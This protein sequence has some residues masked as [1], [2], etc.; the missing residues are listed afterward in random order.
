MAIPL[1]VES[2]PPGL[3]GINLKQSFEPFGMWCGRGHRFLESNPGKAFCD[4]CLL[5]HVGPL[6]V[7]SM[8]H[9]LGMLI[10]HFQTASHGACFDCGRQTQVISA[11]TVK[12]DL[13]SK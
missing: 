13:L 2:L 7:I 4:I 11:R 12:H 9:A 5:S 1:W 10:R 6:P 8:S 3:S